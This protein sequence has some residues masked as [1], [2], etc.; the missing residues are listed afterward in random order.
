MEDT[1]PRLNGRVRLIQAKLEAI[2]LERRDLVVSVHACGG[3]TDLILERAMSV[4]A[5]VAVLPCCHD[6]HKADLGG[7]QGWMDGPL[8]MDVMRA[9]RLRSGGY[10]VMT[11]HIPDNITPKNRLLLAEPDETAHNGI[12]KQDW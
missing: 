11:Q 7:L 8:A 9:E 1:W 10:R 4:G 12:E 3:L 5:R 2:P 6:L